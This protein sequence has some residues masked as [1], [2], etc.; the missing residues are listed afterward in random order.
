MRFKS[1]L[2]KCNFSIQLLIKILFV[3]M[4][5]FFNIFKSNIFF[6]KSFLMLEVH[7]MMFLRPMKFI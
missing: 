7:K 5:P 6:Q 2:K 4:K 3:V 1:K